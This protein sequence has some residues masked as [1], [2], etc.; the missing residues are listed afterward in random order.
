MRVR[1]HGD[2]GTTARLFDESSTA[3]FFARIAGQL[4]RNLADQARR[5]PPMPQLPVLS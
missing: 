3:I 1:E 4:V 2:A 5:Q